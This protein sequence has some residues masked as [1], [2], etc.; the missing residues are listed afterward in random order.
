MALRGPSTRMLDLAGHTVIPGMVDAHGHLLGLGEMLRNVDLVGTKSLADVV[1]RTV[2]RA[3]TLPAGSW[4]LGRGWDQNQWGDTRFPTHDALSNALPDNPVVLSRVD[5]H[6][7]FANAAAMKAA[8]ITAATK[9]P[10]GGR[11]ERDATGEPTGV[12]VDNATSLFNGKIPGPTREEGRAMLRAAIAESQRWGLV[13]IHDAGESRTTIDLMEDMAKAGEFDFR[14]Y[15]MVGDDSA[16][17]AHYLYRGPQNALYGSRLWI[18]AIK[19]YADGA[20]GSP[21]TAASSSPR[22]RTSRKWPHARCAPA[23]R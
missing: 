10:E 12:F 5:G 22:P 7:V 6:A 8:G 9:D 19:L 23:S 16:A 11:I 4:V 2:D 14:L 21:T 20:L 1:Q 13:G 3:K 15:V 17:V 18:R